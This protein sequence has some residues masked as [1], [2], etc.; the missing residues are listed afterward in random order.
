MSIVYLITF[1]YSEWSG[2]QSSSK[3]KFIPFELMISI[4]VTN[5]Q[6]LDGDLKERKNHLKKKLKIKK[7]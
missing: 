7:N 3:H 2:I 1:V 5:L 4:L 6:R